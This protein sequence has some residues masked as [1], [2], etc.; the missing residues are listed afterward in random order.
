MVGKKL[1]RDDAG[2]GGS[3]VVELAEADDLRAGEAF[4]GDAVIGKEDEAAAARLHDFKVAD[5]FFGQCIVLDEG[6]DG[7]VF[8]HQRQRAVFEFAGGVCFGVDVG[9]FFQF[10]R[11]F[12][13]ERVVFAA[14]EVEAAVAVFEAF[15]R[16]GD[17]GFEGEDVVQFARQAIEGGKP[18]AAVGAALQ[19]GDDG[20]DEVEHG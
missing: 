5:D 16:L 19:F 9:K 20:V 13:G 2:D 6:D 3:E 11:T 7:H 18:F 12:G 10:E 17:G 15:R 4:E 14:P 8:V 1:Q